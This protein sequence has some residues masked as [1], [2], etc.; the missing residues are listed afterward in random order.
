MGDRWPQIDAFYHASPTPLL[1]LPPHRLL[2]MVYSWAI[3]RVPSDKLDD[4]LQD[5]RDLLPW[6][7]ASSDAAADLESE[8]FMSMMAKG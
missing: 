6:Q 7:D 3:E 1:R 5:L 8:S 2:N 4:W